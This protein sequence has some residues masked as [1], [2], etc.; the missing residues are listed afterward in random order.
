VEVGVTVERTGEGVRV[1][2]RDGPEQEARINPHAARRRDFFHFN[3][4]VSFI[5]SK[6]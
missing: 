4:I 1:G 3:K 6:F 2:A 5:R